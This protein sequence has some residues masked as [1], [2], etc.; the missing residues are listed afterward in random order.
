MQRDRSDIQYIR[1][2]YEGTSARKPEIHLPSPGRLLPKP[3]RKPKTVIRIDPLALAAMVLSAIMAVVLCVGMV[4][5]EQVRSEQRTLQRYVWDLEDQNEV[6]EQKYGEQYDLNEVRQ[7]ALG[8]GMVPEDQLSHQ[9]LSVTIPQAPETPGIFQ[10][11]ADFF[12]GWFA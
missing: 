6:L 12:R 8:M 7:A 3:V 11:V 2:S 5:L 1:Y 9:S 4:E 10:R